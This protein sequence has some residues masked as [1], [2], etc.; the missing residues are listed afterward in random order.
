MIYVVHSVCCFAVSLSSVVRHWAQEDKSEKAPQKKKQK[1][2]ATGKG[3]GAK[4]SASKSKN[5]SSPKD[6]VRSQTGYWHPQQT[7][8]A[9]TLEDEISD[10]DFR[11]FLMSLTEEELY[12]MMGEHVKNIADELNLPDESSGPNSRIELVKKGTMQYWVL[13]KGEREM[14]HRCLFFC[15]ASLMIEVQPSSS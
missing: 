14:R 11:A 10:E 4:S 13:Q 9:I 2:V 15:R 3:F 12:T 5:S 1:A 8:R 7:A 6:I